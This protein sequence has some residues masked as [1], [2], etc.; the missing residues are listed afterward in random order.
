MGNQQEN[1]EY[2]DWQELPI[3]IPSDYFVDR[4]GNI[5]SMKR[6]PVAKKLQQWD[7]FGKSKNPYKRVKIAGKLMLSHR[8][9][10]SNI[11][12]RAL[13]KNEVVNHR[14]GDTL[15]N[16]LENLEVVSHRENV[17]HA[18]QAKLYCAGEAWYKARGMQKC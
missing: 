6:G 7:H 3:E 2:R 8:V 16:R 13:R 1:L 10:A 4:Y 9:I 5:W 12:G 18:V 11:V 14:N 17:A 15:D